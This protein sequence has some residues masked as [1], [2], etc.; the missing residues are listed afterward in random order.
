MYNATNH[1]YSIVSLYYFYSSDEHEPRNLSVDFC[2]L[3]LVVNNI[4]MDEPNPNTDELFNNIN[5]GFLAG[6]AGSNSAKEISFM[7]FLAVNVLYIKAICF[8]VV[9]KRSPFRTTI[10]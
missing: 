1:P 10:V 9:S 3:I 4:A 7:H 6:S 5:C 8:Y 2:F